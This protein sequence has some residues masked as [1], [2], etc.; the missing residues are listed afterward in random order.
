MENIFHV[1]FLIKDRKIA[2]VDSEESSLPE[3]IPISRA[4]K[5]GHIVSGFRGKIGD[6][7][8]ELTS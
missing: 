2:M 4:E 1:S 6:Q 5:T 7:T 8:L 3:L